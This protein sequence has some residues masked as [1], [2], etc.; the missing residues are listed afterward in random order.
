[1]SAYHY[2]VICR[3]RSSTA[4]DCYDD[5][6]FVRLYDLPQF[7]TNPLTHRKN[8]V[9]QPL[10][11]LTIIAFA[12]PSASGKT[13]LVE[14]IIRENSTL[15]KKWRQIT[16]R[17]RRDGEGETY[18]F[19]D[20]EEFESIASLLT[21]VTNFG[22]MRYGT[23]PEA[24]GSDDRIVLTIVDGVGMK[25]LLADVAAHNADP[26]SGKLNAAFTYNVVRVLMKY[27]VVRCAE[28]VTNRPG[29]DVNTVVAELTRLQ[30]DADLKWDIELDTTSAW[31]SA[32]EFL[33]QLGAFVKSPTPS[34]VPITTAP[35]P[36]VETDATYTEVRLILCQ[37]IGDVYMASQIGHVVQKLLPREREMLA[38]AISPR[39]RY[40]TPATSGE[41]SN[42]V[43]RN[44]DG[45]GVTAA[46]DWVND[47]DFHVQE[48]TLGKV[49]DLLSQDRVASDILE[50]SGL[51]EDAADYTLEAAMNA[52]LEADEVSRALNAG[53]D[54][55]IT[56]H[57]TQVP[58]S[59]APVPT[60]SPSTK[61]PPVP[62]PAPPA[63][64]PVAA[65]A[66]SAI[67]M[68]SQ[69]FEDWVLEE[70]IG[71]DAFRDATSFRIVLRQFVSAHGGLVDDGIMVS[72]QETRD[73]LNGVIAGFTASDITQ[74]WT[75]TV[76][77]NRRLTRIVRM[78][79]DGH[80]N[81]KR[82]HRVW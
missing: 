36:I 1:M 58:I 41:V 22:G 81:G 75:F 56:G 24:Q 47:R 68:N 49:L 44:D 61:A 21:C 82:F 77:F 34:E 38:N 67:F 69:S 37:L 39:L 55:A 6:Q 8:P 12:G 65:P 3:K 72:V 32:G 10:P 19:V 20:P 48:L 73:N 31:V 13:E 4:R 54:D 17:S 50:A 5:I 42:P 70:G 26:S 46:S 57:V 35:E 64:P 29:R 18:V 25:S 51:S 53:F 33:N 52:Q 79:F 59:A 43:S 9:K 66:T 23:I 16:T 80:T 30:S 63:A 45:T 7:P 14:A 78:E 28:R 71:I 62:V 2:L 74:G 76:E 40:T 11:C 27:D 60:P 15:T